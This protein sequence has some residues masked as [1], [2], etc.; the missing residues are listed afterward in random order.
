[1]RYRS[2]NLYQDRTWFD[3]LGERVMQRV[4]AHVP[5]DRAPLWTLGF[6][7]FA[8]LCLAWAAGLATWCILFELPRQQCIAQLLSALLL[9]VS[10]CHF[11]ALTGSSAAQRRA[12]SKVLKPTPRP[13]QARMTTPRTATDPTETESTQTTEIQ[14]PAE[15]QST[16]EVQSAVEVQSAAEVQSLTEAQSTVEVQS[17]TEAQSP[18]DVQSPAQTQ[19]QTETPT[20]VQTAA[21]EDSSARSDFFRAVKAAGINVRIARALYA[22]G[23]RSADQVQQASDAD[24]LAAHGIGKATLRKLRVKFGLPIVPQD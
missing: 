19:P 11:L 10:A 4:M 2:D 20:P 13:R 9:L 6:A 18:A 7:I 23:F 5:R 12:Q 22:A 14:S 15:V 3:V 16:A 21:A 8:G 1:M 17:L 24:L